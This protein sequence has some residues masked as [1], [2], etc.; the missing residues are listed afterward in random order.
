MQVQVQVCVAIEEGVLVESE[1]EVSVYMCVAGR[2][3]S[4]DESVCHAL[5]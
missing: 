5:L 3:L 4:R 2:I 1:R